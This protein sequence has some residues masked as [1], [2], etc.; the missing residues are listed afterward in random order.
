M[1]TRVLSVPASAHHHPPVGHPERAERFNAVLDGV[2]S[3]GVENVEWDGRADRS[4]LERVH[5]QAH[6]DRVFGASPVAGEVALDADTHMSPGS[7]EAALQA[8]GAAIAAVDQVLDGEAEA[9]FVA[10]RP[11]GHHAE[12]DRAMG[13]C[14]FNTIAIAAMHAIEARGLS[15]AAVVDVD[16]HHGNGTQA[17]A[18]DE[19]R[20]SFTSLHQGWIY[21]GT[22]AAHETGVYGNVLNV[23]FEAGT[24]PEAWLERFDAEVLPKLEND[25]PEVLLVSV[26]FDAHADDPLAGLALTDA[27]YG[28]IAARLATA[29]RKFSHSRLV[30]V[31]EGGYDCHAL[32]RSTKTFLDALVAG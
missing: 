15:A 26:G 6:I 18:E 29:A 2:R 16:V 27:A 9:V 23:V 3:S 25:R 19:P 11:P 14:L 7:L 30:C 10:A 31:L 21:P 32:E 24:G 22:G 8:A 20:L 28:Q 4:A 5:V 17:F 12:P 13:F 1:K